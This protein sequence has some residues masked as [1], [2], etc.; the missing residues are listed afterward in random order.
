M[1]IDGVKPSTETKMTM[2]N[3]YGGFLKWWVS[4]TNPWVFSLLKIV[5]L[6][7]EMGVPPLRKHPY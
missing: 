1:R 4:L 7:C 5:I 2:A 3:P 6:G